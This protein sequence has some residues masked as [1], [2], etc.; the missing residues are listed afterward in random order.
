MAA[1][2]TEALL[3]RNQGLCAWCATPVVKAAGAWHH[4]HS[5]AARSG[6][7]IPLCLDG[8]DDDDEDDGDEDRGPDDDYWED[9]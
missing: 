3:A 7:V 6:C 8:Y 1:E 2:A 9:A 5:L 4:S